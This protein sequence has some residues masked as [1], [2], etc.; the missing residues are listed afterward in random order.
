MKVKCPHCK[1]ETEYSP[2]NPYRPFCSE[3]CRLIDLGMW[4]SEEYRVPSQE[5]ISIDIAPPSENEED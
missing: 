3:R 2:E 1:K 5:K 4:A